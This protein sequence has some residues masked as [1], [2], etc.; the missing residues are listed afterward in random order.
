[1]RTLHFIDEELSLL[2]ADSAEKMPAAIIASGGVP[3]QTQQF[4]HLNATLIPSAS[5]ASTSVGH[6]QEIQA[7]SA[8]LAADWMLIVTDSLKPVEYW[9]WNLV[10]PIAHDT[11]NRVRAAHSLSLSPGG[12]INMAG[13]RHHLT[14][15]G[16]GR[17]LKLPY[18][19]Y[20]WASLH[21]T[22]LCCH[23]SI[24][25]CWGC[26]ACRGYP[27]NYLTGVVDDLSKEVEAATCSSL[28]ID[29]KL[30]LAAT[31]TVPAGKQREARRPA[32]S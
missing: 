4:R 18:M 6:L 1:M 24:R 13:L 30:L 12:T 7:A 17:V 10:W 11:T 20:R 23:P 28:L 25:C 9:L 29:R 3:V 15:V 22:A 31:G 8:R 21:A 32:V 16:D 14:V 5:P 19:L 27:V 26:A 2:L